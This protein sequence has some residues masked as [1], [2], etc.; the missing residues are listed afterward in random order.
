MY[1]LKE[2]EEIIEEF[3]GLFRPKRTIHTKKIGV[4]F[5]K[6]K[7]KR[8]SAPIAT[9]T[10]NDGRPIYA[11]LQGLQ[12]N[13]SDS[14]GV[15]SNLAVTLSDT[16]VVTTTVKTSAS[17][18]QYV[19]FDTLGKLASTTATF[20]CTVT[21]PTGPVAN[22]TATATV[23]VTAGPGDVVTTSVEVLFSSS[24]PA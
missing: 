18:I 8:M 5:Y 11:T 20:T 3:F 21:D 4:V 2:I 16:T 15:V 14:N 19:E 10:T 12:S 1:L 23:T 9:G 24:V 17:G 7:P 13:G 22:F 6:E